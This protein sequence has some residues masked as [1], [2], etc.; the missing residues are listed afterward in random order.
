MPFDIASLDTLA[1]SQAGVPMPV[2]HPRTRAPI[3]QDSG[4]D[5]GKPHTITLC[6]RNSDAHREMNRIVEDRRS[7]MAARGIAMTREDIERDDV[8][9]L[10]ACTKA[11]TLEVLDGQP[12]PFNEANARKLWGDRRFVVVRDQAIRHIREDANFLPA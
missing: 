12:F 10:T 7:D 4:P 3:L 2:L 11:W 1:R 8:D 5:S 6:G 9:V